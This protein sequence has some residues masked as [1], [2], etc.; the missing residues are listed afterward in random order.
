MKQ[1]LLNFL[2]TMTCP[3]LSS[4]LQQVAEWLN[5]FKSKEMDILLWY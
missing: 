1:L 4:S 2:F 5:Q 3:G